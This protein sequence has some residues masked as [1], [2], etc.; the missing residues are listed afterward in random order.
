[1]LLKFEDYQYTRPDMENVK[2]EFNA[3]LQDFRS[4]SS[5]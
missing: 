5:L 4:A 3:L 1:M 2:Q